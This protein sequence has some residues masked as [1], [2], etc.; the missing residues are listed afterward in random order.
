MIPETFDPVAVFDELNRLGWRDAKIEL[1]CGL[2]QSTV[3]QWRRGN[4]ESMGYTAAARLLNF[5][6][7]ERRKV[8]A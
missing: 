3:A 2:A 5:L 4:R 1:A 7:A 8:A 6:E